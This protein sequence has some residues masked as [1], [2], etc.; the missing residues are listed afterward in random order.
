MYKGVVK[1]FDSKKGYGFIVVEGKEKDVFVH[2]SAINQEG[3][4]SL[5]Q[6]QKVTLDIEE[7]KKGEQASNV[8][9]VNE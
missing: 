9:V 6:G 2:Y 3:H 7:G 8:T 1:F 4:K 5:E